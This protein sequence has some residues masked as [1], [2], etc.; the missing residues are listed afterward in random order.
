MLSVILP[1]Y[2]EAGNI[3]PLIHALR[4]ELA[5]V[6][7]EIIVVDDDSP[8]GTWKLVETESKS[9]PELKLLRRVGRRGLASALRDGI[10]ASS[11]DLVGWMDCDFSTPP[12]VVPRLAAKISEGFD[13]AV[14]SRYVPGGRDARAGSPWRRMASRVI[15]EFAR[16]MLIR[17]FHDYTSGFVVARREVLDSIP[18]RG[19]H[20][21]YFMDFIVRALRSGRRIVEVP[22]VL[23][24]RRHGESK[25]DSGFFRKG[26]KYLAMVGRLWLEARSSDA[27]AGIPR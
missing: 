12:N 6:E 25:T 1:T 5:G 26:L 3:V 18:L 14:A 16:A 11:G 13:I 4:E 22:Y 10:R 19:D 2:N 9:L 7:F 20:G 27:P 8:D 15:V 21:E 23:V 17:D 24:P